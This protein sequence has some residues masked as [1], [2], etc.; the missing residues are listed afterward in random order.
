M[1]LEAVLPLIGIILFFIGIILLI[2]GGVKKSKKKS[3]E[4]DPNELIA[5]GILVSIGVLFL[6]GP[7]IIN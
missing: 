3:D 1:A 5:G 4:P 7:I 2:V 6:G